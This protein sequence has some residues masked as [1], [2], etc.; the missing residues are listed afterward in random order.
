MKTITLHISH[1][2]CCV[3]LI[4]L[5][6]ATPAMAQQRKTATRKPQTTKTTAAKPSTKKKNTKNNKKQAKPGKKPATPTTPAIKGL[7]NQRLKIQGEIKRQEK[8]LQAN[9]ADV[10]K[11]LQNLEILNSAISERQK[12][13]EGIQQDITTIDGN[14]NLLASQL[15]TLNTQ[16]NDHKARY[17]KSLRYM[18]RNHNVQDKMMFVFSADNLA[19]MFRRARFVRQYA[20][21][22]RAQGEAVMAKQRQVNEKRQQLEAAR[23]EKNVLLRKDQQERKTL[24]GQQDEQQKMVTSLQR[25]QKT[26][27]G[28]IDDQ[29]RKDAALNAQIDRLIAEEVAK[30]KARAEAEARKKAAAE[31]AA[32]KRAAELARRKAAAEAAAREN[33]RRVAEAREREEKAKAAARR[34]TAVNRQRAEQAAREAEADRKAAELKARTDE[35]RSRKEIAQAKKNAEETQ[36]YS[37]IDRKLSGS[38]EANKGRLPMPITGSFR[39]VSHFGQY[40]V[41]GLRGVTLDNKGINILGTKGCQARSIFEG[42]VSAVFSYAGSNVVMVRHGSYISVY[43]NLRSVS[44]STGQ[45][46]STR[47][48]LG[49]V[50]TDNILQFQLRRGTAKLNPEQW[51]S[52]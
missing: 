23:S 11:R 28:I 32:K 25:Q 49:T 31:A 1:S 24:Q 16:L 19:Q 15:T 27:Q 47:Q 44:V 26:I 30:A 43:C 38:F 42:E 35:E 2:I 4:A 10:K 9:R 29:K 13:I 37:S 21:F 17:V 6:M 18:A 34:A 8:A 22:Q 52:R 12:S 3:A 46:V 36:M 50:G 33:A 20:A 41:E 14:I 48:V 40:N 39:I 7:Q 51:V 45:H 5:I